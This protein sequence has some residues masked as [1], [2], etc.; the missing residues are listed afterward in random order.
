MVIKG[1]TLFTG[2]SAEKR[3]GAIVIS[4][5]AQSVITNAI[6]TSNTAPIGGAIALWS[7]F[8]NERTYDDCV[9]IGNTAADGGAMYLYGDSGRD[10]ITGS[11]F[12]ENYASENAPTC[13]KAYIWATRVYVTQGCFISLNWFSECTSGIKTAVSPP[14]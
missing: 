3:G 7:P 14:L 5:S 6:F 2:N 12:R 1:N 11:V 8:P 10:I 4:Q 9:F 13:D